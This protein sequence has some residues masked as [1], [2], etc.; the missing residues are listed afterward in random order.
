MNAKISSSQAHGLRPT[1]VHTSA[2]TRV[3]KGRKTKPSS[4]NTNEPLNAL[5]TSGVNIQTSTRA[6][7]VENM[8]NNANKQAQPMSLPLRAK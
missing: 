4:G 5:F 1:G 3:V 7:R 6:R 8:V 2:Y